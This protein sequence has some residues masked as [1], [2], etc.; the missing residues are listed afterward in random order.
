M[1]HFIVI[2]ALFVL[3]SP[4]AAQSWQEYSYP[5][6]SFSVSFP[7]APQTGTV[8]FKVGG[9]RAVAARVYSVRRD[10]AEFKVTVAEIGNLGLE[11]KAVI[12]QAIKALS[13]GG[14]VRVN[15][16][17]RINR[18]FGRQISILLEDG[19]RTSAALFDFNGRL[20]QIEGRSL[21][22]GADSTADA[23]RFV[24]SLVFTGG[25][26]NRPADELRAGRGACDAAG[27]RGASGRGPDAPAAGPGGAGASADAPPD[28]RRRFEIRCR[29]QQAFAALTSSLNASDLSGARQAW[30][31]LGE[32]P[33]FG[34]PDGPFAQAVSQIGQA[35]QNG[36]LPAA[37]QALASLPRGGRGGGNREPD[38]GRGASP[39]AAGPR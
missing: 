8:T 6:Y 21:P 32:L 25:G 19:S 28:E 22:T 31:S 27:G 14:E 15:I 23:I 33:R 36:D 17:H 39:D 4:A 18:V 1:K 2:L 7:A 12:D 10:D 26:S 13:S 9:D 5:D 35:L 34:N 30:S 38:G 20:Y 29:R 37:Q 24:Q 3:A 16:P 11:E